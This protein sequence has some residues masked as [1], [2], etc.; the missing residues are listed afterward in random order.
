MPNLLVILMYFTKFS[1]VFTNMLLF[2]FYFA[3][4]SNRLYCISISLDN[5]I[6]LNNSLFT[7]AGNKVIK[8][9]H[10]DLIMTTVEALI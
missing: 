4:I 7:L 6:N 5:Y 3:K 1:L 10:S 2:S 9:V 8:I